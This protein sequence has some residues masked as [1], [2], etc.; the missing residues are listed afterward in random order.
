MQILHKQ[1][2]ISLFAVNQ[3]V[4]QTLGHQNTEAT[5]SLAL[6]LASFHVLE[7]IIPGIAESAVLQL[8]ERKALARISH[9]AQHHVSGAHITHFHV[10]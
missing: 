4:H 7:G 2:I 8:F 3:V 10:L 9:P 5:R 1:N 6:C